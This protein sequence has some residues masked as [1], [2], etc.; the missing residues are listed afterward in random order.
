MK[1]IAKIVMCFMFVFAFANFA[2][3]QKVKTITGNLCK[4]ENDGNYFGTIWLRA[5]TKVIEVAHHF[6]LATGEKG[7]TTK[8]I[9]NPDLDKIGSEYIVKYTTR[10][11]YNTATSIRFAG[12]MKKAT[13]CSVS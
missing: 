10:N 1:N 4:S 8:Y 6:R 2:Q 12:R 9:N 3:A 5:G 13:P 7:N 11:G